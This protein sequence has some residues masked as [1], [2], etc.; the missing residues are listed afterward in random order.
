VLNGVKHQF[1]GNK[2]STSL[3]A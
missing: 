2:K 1:T 3:R